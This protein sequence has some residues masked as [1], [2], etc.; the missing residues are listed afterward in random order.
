[1]LLK[2]GHVAGQGSR[3]KRR[4]HIARPTAADQIAGQFAVDFGDRI[5]SEY[6]HNCQIVV[7]GDGQ[8]H[9]M[10][11]LR[12]SQATMLIVTEP[13]SSIEPIECFHGGKRILSP[14]SLSGQPVRS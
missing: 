1:M 3:A 13:P 12:K 14:E 2:H 6:R 5:L 7:G 4:P 8:F 11:V 10:L 9:G